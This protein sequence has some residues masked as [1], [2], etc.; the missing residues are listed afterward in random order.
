MEMGCHHQHCTIVVVVVVVVALRCLIGGHFMVLR[1]IFSPTL[2]WEG[3]AFFQFVDPCSVT[4]R[5]EFPCSYLNDGGGKVTLSHLRRYAA[6][7]RPPQETGKFFFWERNADAWVGC[8]ES[9]ER[10]NE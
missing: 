2:N 9:S 8:D 6:M 10:M 7:V 5:K 1:L 3:N 4:G